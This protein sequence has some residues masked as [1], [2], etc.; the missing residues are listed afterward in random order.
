M[1]GIGFNSYVAADLGSRNLYIMSN[2]QDAPYTCA[3]LAL[4]NRENVSDVYAVGEEAVRL[5]GRT[6]DD[7]E[8]VYPIVCGG[9]S[10]SELAAMLLLSGAEKALERRHPFE[11]SKLL[12]SVPCGGTRVEKSALGHAAELAG[13]KHAVIVKAPIAQAIGIGCKTDKTEGQLIVSIGASVTEITVISAYGVALS[14]H[15]KLGSSMFDS[16]ISE[17]IRN[18]YGLLVPDYTA[19]GIKKDMASAVKEDRN[20]SI[21]LRGLNIRTGRPS[22][23]T[24][25]S[26]DVYEALKA[27]LSFI[28][29]RICDALFSVP[30]EFSSD[31]L[32]NGIY[33]SGGGS[34]LH[35]CAEMLQNA[36]SLEVHQSSKPALDTINGLSKIACDDKLCRSLISAGTAYEI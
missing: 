3:S 4:V 27:P 8:M 29:G 11:K 5:E 25:T 16:A 22:S 33:L 35:G 26:N 1:A 34:M 18:S 19:E 28:V 20:S 6:G 23:E 30:A 7:A 15:I 10:D 24:I 21:T 14:R 31:I 2:D 12:L 17:Q 32:K 13:A 9:V 36:T